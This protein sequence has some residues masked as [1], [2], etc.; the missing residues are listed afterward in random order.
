[1][2]AR[3]LQTR[4]PS[5]LVQDAVNAAA[6]GD[7]ELARRL[8]DA[9]Y[10]S[11]ED[12]RD[13]HG[14][15]HWRYYWPRGNFEEVI[16]GFEQDI[17]LGRLSASW[18]VNLGMA[19]ARM[20]NLEPAEEAVRIAYRE[21]P[22][23]KDGFSL[24]GWQ[25]FW[26][27]REYDELLKS[28]LRDEALHRLTPRQRCLQAK[29]YAVAGH[30]DKAV[31]C[32]DKAYSA[33][34]DLT[35]CL[36]E[37]AKL[38]L[39]L[40]GSR[41]AALR[42]MEMDEKNGRLSSGGRLLLAEALA[43]SSALDA[44][45]EIRCEKALA[46]VETAYSAMPELKDGYANV[47]RGLSWV[48]GAES[49]TPLYRLDMDTHH[50]SQRGFRNY[51]QHVFMAFGEEAAR[52][53]AEEGYSRDAGWRGGF[54]TLG[55]CLLKHGEPGKAIECFKRDLD[56][57][58]ALLEIVIQGMSMLPAS[59]A[60]DRLASLVRA[61]AGNRNALT[62]Y[63]DGLQALKAGSEPPSAD[64]PMN[65]LPAGDPHRWLGA[66]A[67]W[68]STHSCT[69][70]ARDQYAKNLELRDG[71]SCAARSALYAGR[72]SKAIELFEADRRL[73]RIEPDSLL[74][75]AE[76]LRQEGDKDLSGSLLEE[77]LHMYGLPVDPWLSKNRGCH[78]LERCFV[79]GTG[80]SMQ[81]ID[82]SLLTGQ[83]VFAVN[84]AIYLDHLEPT[85]F[86]SV[87]DMFWRHHLQAIH[88]LK[89][90]RFLPHWMRGPLDSESPTSWL[91]APMP[92]TTDAIGQPM[93]NPLFF[94]EQAERF[95]ALGG[96]VMF[97]CLQLAWHMGFHEIIF[98]GLDHN[99]G[100]S[101]GHTPGGAELR[102]DRF[103]EAHFM[104]QYYRGGFFN[105]DVFGMERAYSLGLEQ[106]ERSGGRILNATPGTRLDTY[107]K[108]ALESIL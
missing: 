93:G 29:V 22:G 90:R 102:A 26:P 65:D 2:T 24:V 10:E 80:P 1:M 3:D 97:V 82:C 66:M 32:A 94:S 64:F 50:L 36:L 107:P 60:M 41:T 83:T 79:V 21:H 71:L 67:P 49:V 106:F 51:L 8:V 53:L 103:S 85:Y 76:V 98:L 88:E 73:K 6:N 4:Q 99:Y 52:K 34:D 62:V 43:L 37:A 44:K 63:M 48:E 47:A 55:M 72:K 74:Q 15:I 78:N 104:K 46:L 75:Y 96:T 56:L 33:D 92:R 31:A 95:I 40:Q 84:G 91:N 42:L 59:E 30:I 89:F 68:K 19:K 87:S 11:T 100:T 57:G 61:Q 5:C 38:V 45:Q 70:F 20:G 9:A 17:E 81:Q 105:L 58:R 101:A 77:A 13:G 54:S 27:R 35:D 39:A 69:Q 14:R 23:V 12:V 108:V 18:W 28:F 16:K 86:V 7:L 25:W